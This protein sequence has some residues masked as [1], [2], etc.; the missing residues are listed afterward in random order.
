[1]NKLDDKDPIQ[2]R[3]LTEGICPRCHIPMTRT[4][5]YVAACPSAQ[6][7]VVWR[8]KRVAVVFCKEDTSGLHS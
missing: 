6:C 1:M 3:Y 7:D 4:A 2:N 5:Q 8:S